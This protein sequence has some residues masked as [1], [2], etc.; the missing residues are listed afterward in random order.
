MARSFTNR[1]CH[2]PRLWD[3]T[4]VKSFPKKFI[5][6]SN[7]DVTTLPTMG[8]ADF[9]QFVSHPAWKLDEIASFIWESEHR[10]DDYSIR[11]ASCFWHDGHDRGGGVLDKP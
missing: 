8:Y 7:M 10:K 2:L 1:L 5:D 3:A 4:P 11:K 9:I 6:E